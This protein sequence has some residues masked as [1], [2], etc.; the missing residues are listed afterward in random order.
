MIGPESPLWS[1]GV[2]FERDVC[3]FP[4]FLF[5]EWGL[6]SLFSLPSSLPVF[7]IGFGWS[8]ISKGVTSAICEG[9]LINLDVLEPLLFG[10][11]VEG[12]V[13]ICGRY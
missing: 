3:F 12:L 13:E 2:C 9:V 11:S 5:F 1:R 7:L 4:D 8:I 10:R 6:E